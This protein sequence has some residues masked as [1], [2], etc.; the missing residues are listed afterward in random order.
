LT[1]RDDALFGSDAL[2]M[3]DGNIYL[4]RSGF[5][6]GLS[7]LLRGKGE[8]LVVSQENIDREKENIG[9]YW[10][11]MMYV[12]ILS[13]SGDDAKKRAIGHWHDVARRIGSTD[14][15]NPE[16]FLQELADKYPMMSSYASRSEGSYDKNA[17]I[18]WVVGKIANRVVDSMFSLPPLDMPSTYTPAN[19][20]LSDS[21]ADFD[22]ESFINKTNTVFDRI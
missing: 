4:L 18:R 2:L 21:I 14:S 16:Q 10:L 12:K 22:Y 15:D 8:Q 9:R 11:V 20:T 3:G 5:Y 17:Q 13:M 1:T 7:F 19:I 6:R